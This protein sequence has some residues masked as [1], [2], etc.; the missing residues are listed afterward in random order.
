MD[1]I[2]LPFQEATD[3]QPTGIDEGA[4]SWRAALDR[5]VQSYA[6]EHYP[7]GVVTV[8][9]LCEVHCMFVKQSP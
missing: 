5:A 1:N 2:V 4:E 7:N 8:S 6:K 9:V 3:V